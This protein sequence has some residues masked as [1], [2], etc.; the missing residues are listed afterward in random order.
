MGLAIS[1]SLIQMHEGSIWLESELGEGSIFTFSVPLA[2]GENTQNVGEPP[3]PLVVTSAPT[4]LVVEDD[5]EIST[6]LVIALE[7]EGFHVLS[8]SS[9]EEA[10]RIV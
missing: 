10:L 2:E 1:L 6:M 7:S 5:R 3:E 8:A 4:I 9:G